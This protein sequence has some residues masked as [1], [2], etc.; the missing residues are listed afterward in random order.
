MSNVYV[1]EAATAVATE[2]VSQIDAALAQTGNR[3][4]RSI[5]LMEASRGLDAE[6]AALGDPAE[7]GARAERLRAQLAQLSDPATVAAQRQVMSRAAERLR[8]IA[9]A[10]G[11]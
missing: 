9:A 3:G 1:E 4:R 7:I 10:G 6:A 5:E 8:V 11:V 2:I